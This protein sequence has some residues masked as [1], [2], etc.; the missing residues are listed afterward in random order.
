MRTDF[1][2]DAVFSVAHPFG[3]GDSIAFDPVPWSFTVFTEDLPAGPAVEIFTYRPEKNLTSELLTGRVII[4]A[5]TT[6]PI[7]SIAP[8][9][10]PMFPEWLGQLKGRLEVFFNGAIDE[11]E[12]DISA[13]DGAG[14]FIHRDMLQ[15]A[16]TPDGFAVS[17]PS[18]LYHGQRP[19]TAA[20][21]IQPNTGDGVSMSWPESRTHTFPLVPIPD[22]DAN[23]NG[24]V[25]F[26]DFLKLSENF[27][28]RAGA[29]YQQGDFSYDRAVGFADFIILSRN[30]GRASEL[31]SVQTATIPEPRGMNI[32]LCG[33][34][35]LLSVR[36]LPARKPKVHSTPHTN[37]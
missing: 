35:A 37:R 32:I 8:F 31:T 33:L 28:V 23:G 19:S 3:A 16:I 2:L 1:Q 15:S 14:F 9:N 34:V 36:R 5:L 11:R 26:D 25:G 13:W 21:P 22:G 18:R 6:R 4:D 20:G 7:H 30:F 29:T 24:S 12:F 10:P 27:G 17:V